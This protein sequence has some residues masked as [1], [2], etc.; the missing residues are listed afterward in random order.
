MIYTENLFNENISKWDNITNI[1][2]NKEELAKFFIDG[3]KPEFAFVG[4]KDWVITRN[5]NGVNGNVTFSLFS[6]ESFIKSTY[7]FI[8]KQN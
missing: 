8:T 1:K 4:N 3:D 7:Y 6:R 2:G 5:V